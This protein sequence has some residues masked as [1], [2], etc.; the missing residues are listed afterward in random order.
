SSIALHDGLPALTW[1]VLLLVRRRS[2]HGD[3][4]SLIDSL[5]LTVGLSLLSWVLLIAPYLHDPT[6]GFL[7]KLVSVAYPIGDIIL[8]AAAVRLALD[9]GRHRPAFHL[10]GASIVSLLTTDFV[11]GVMTLH[12]SYHHQL[13]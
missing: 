1:G 12:G 7:S 10:L 3:R 6:M 13:L 8:L 11:Y 9:A 2:P 5:I 4:N